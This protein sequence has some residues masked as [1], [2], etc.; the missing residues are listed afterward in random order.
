MVLSEGV[1]YPDGQILDEDYEV[2][3]F[4]QSK[5]YEKGV[6]CNDCHDVHRAKRYSE[7][8]E[9]CMK[10]HRA[11]TYDTETASLPQKSCGRE[12][13]R[14]RSL[15]FLPYAGPQLHG[16][17]FQARSQPANSAPGS[18]T[19]DRNAQ[20]VQPVGLPCRQAFDLGEPKLRQVVRRQAQTSLWNRH[21][22]RPGWKSR[23][24][25][26]ICWRYQQTHSPRHCASHGARSPVEI[27]GRR[28]QRRYWSMR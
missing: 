25:T 6:K 11:D 2:H 23:C 22:R 7:G 12:A 20:R 10:C 24:P 4:E 5:M 19:V 1:F 16:G 27:S 14:R 8:N 21:R 17:P 28:E 26:P 9:L 3:S 18:D 15:R 13:E